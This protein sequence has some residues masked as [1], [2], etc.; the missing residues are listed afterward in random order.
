MEV[1][2]EAERQAFAT[3]LREV[4]AHPVIAADGVWDEVAARAK[5]VAAGVAISQHV[6]GTMFA[7]FFRAMRQ[8]GRL[9]P[10]SQFK[11]CF[12]SIAHGDEEQSST[13]QV[14]EFAFAE[15]ARGHTA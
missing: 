2:I 6:T 3:A 10:P 8:R 9:L 13:L 4:R 12:V 7:T 1:I 14:G 11:A 5:A 15:V